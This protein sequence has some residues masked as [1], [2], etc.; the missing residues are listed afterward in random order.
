MQYNEKDL[1]RR[2]QQFQSFDALKGFR[3]ILKEKEI[4]KFKK[5]ELCEEDKNL[6]DYQVNYIKKGMIITVIYFEKGNFYKVNGIVS[7]INLDTHFLQIVKTKINMLNI[8][9]IESI[10][11][12]PFE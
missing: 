8:V 12:N 5:I 6:L 11:Y 7:K 2:A 9:K 4:Q 1:I 3:E 10:S